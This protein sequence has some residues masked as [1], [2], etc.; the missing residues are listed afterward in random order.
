MSYKPSISAV[1]RGND[2]YSD[3]AYDYDLQQE[4]A[5][6]FKL[7]AFLDAIKFLVIGGVIFYVNYTHQVSL[8]DNKSIYCCDCYYIATN[9]EWY[10]INT[11]YRIDWSF[12]TP[13]C[14]NCTY[15]NSTFNNTAL[16]SFYYSNNNDQQKQCPLKDYTPPQRTFLSA[17]KS[18]YSGD[19]PNQLSMNTM[20]L[21][22]KSYYTY[23]IG[24]ISIVILYTFLIFSFIYCCKI[25]S[26][27]N[28]LLYNIVISEVLF[29]LMFKPYQYY[30]Q[31]ISYPDNFELS[32]FCQVDA[33]DE[34]IET[35]LTIFIY[36]C[37]GFIVIEW[38]LCLSRCC[39][40]K[41]EHKCRTMYWGIERYLILFICCVC[42]LFFGVL[43]YSSVIMIV[44]RIKHETG[45][46]EKRNEIIIIICIDIALLI[47]C[48]DI[49]LF[50]F[51]RDKAKR[52]WN[53]RKLKS[54]HNFYEKFG[55]SESYMD[56]PTYHVSDNDKR[57]RNVKSNAG[58][59]V[60]QQE[61]QDV[62]ENGQ[63]KLTI[64][65]KY[66]H[67]YLIPNDEAKASVK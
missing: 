11:K 27:V 32:T 15:C 24:A 21:F 67:E 8:H 2:E 26:G 16:D 55:K 10:G 61:D 35:L 43:I 53:A 59:I 1:S 18:K 13:D 19:C 57:K 54:D 23:G 49:F 39:W 41:W 20:E 6:R 28:L 40:K 9:S 22:N 48:I 66:K 14:T 30:Q 31:Q 44:E 5:S 25:L 29:Y 37:L 38:I 17:F 12:C 42:L 65:S 64:P 3:Y 62:E 46:K 34:T 50:K 7:Y 33:I 45:E 63:K 58:A 51:C 56:D 4:I 60:E 52:I 36:C 47:S